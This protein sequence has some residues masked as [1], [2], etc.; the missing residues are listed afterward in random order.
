MF[1]NFYKYLLLKLNYK[2]LVIKLCLLK[3]VQ[4]PN[5]QCSDCKDHEICM[6][7]LE[8]SSFNCSTF[9]NDQN[10]QLKGYF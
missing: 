5:H 3:T 8:T 2:E 1:R 7:Q 6:F 10:E 4:D 9:H